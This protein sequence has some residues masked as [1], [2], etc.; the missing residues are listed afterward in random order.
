[1]N[2]MFQLKQILKK[3]E[4]D[5]FA[6]S[7]SDEFFLEYLPE[8]EKR[9]QYLTGFTGSNAHLIISQNS[10]KFFTDGRY[11]LQANHELDLKEFEIFNIAEK[12]LLSW[13]KE[14]LL[15]GKKIAIDPKLVTINFV[16]ALKKIT[17]EN[18]ANL[19]FLDPNPVDK[20]WENRPAQKKSEIFFC[21][22]K[23]TG[24]NFDEKK[25]RILAQIKADALLISSP[26]NLCWLLNVRAG[27]IEYTPIL[28]A[29]AI[30]F[31]DGKI[32][33]FVDADRFKKED[34]EKLKNVNL[35]QK[36]CFD[37]RIS[38]L[39]KSFSKIQIDPK[40]TNYWL[41]ELLQKNN[42]EIIFETDPIIFAKAIKNKS[43]IE[44]AINAHKADGAALTEFLL[45]MKKSLENG[46]ELDEIKC[47]EKLLEFR[48]KDADFLYPSFAS[49]SSFAGNGAVI[50]YHAS[51]KTNKKLEGNSLYLIDSGGQYCGAKSFGTTDVTR[52]IAIGNP[53]KEMKEN[54]TLVL[55]CHIALATAK[56]P[57][58][59]TGAQLD[60][61]T[62]YHLWQNNKDYDH[63]TG[64]GVGSFLS[65]HE[66]P[67]SISKS[68]HQPLF[69]GMILSNE[70]GFYKAGEYGIRIENLMLVEK[71]D[72]KFLQFRV[73][74]LVPIDL[75]L[76]DYSI[77]TAQEKIWLE[78]Y[79]KAAEENFKKYRN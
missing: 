30:L 39:R 62:R 44:G 56:F 10:S 22:E 12:S 40:L 24:E 41:Y 49:I 1:M 21:D 67:C 25:S 66:G 14:N 20:I 18:R 17:Q 8:S 31:K 43:E 5:F 72:E 29:Y 55:K 51:Q 76:V 59:T 33:L 11:I 57:P 68:N 70:P 28:A 42:F 7:N 78:S 6:L 13:L 27:D 16:N 58:A 63:G 75:N 77:L 48:K 74:T 9:I 73:L 32:D 71:Y 4:I 64:H 54:F 53:T 69:E 60:A 52:T 47:E 38:I 37:L 65:V 79:N 2:V 46:E 50:H 34:L 36:N 26:E 3:E 23:L 35:V 15:E 19:V 45:W 61:I